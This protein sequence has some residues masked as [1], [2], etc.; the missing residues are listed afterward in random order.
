MKTK[1]WLIA[2]LGLI[3]CGGILFGG[4][5]MALN[6]DFT[7]LSTVTYETNIHSPGSDFTA[8]VVETDTANITFVPTDEGCSVTCVDDIRAKHQVY[9]EDGTLFIINDSNRKWYDHIGI[10]IGS[11]KITVRLPQ[12]QYEAL[13]VKT[14]TGDVILDRELRFGAM[15]LTVTTGSLQLTGISAE[16]LL[17]RSTTGRVYLSQVTCTGL[18]GITVDT[19]RIVAKDVHCR[20]LAAT[21]G[22]GDITLINVLA[23]ERLTVIGGT[24]DVELSAC[25]AREINVSTATGNV[26]GTLRSGKTFDAETDTG[27]VRVPENSGHGTCHIRTKTGDIHITVE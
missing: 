19:G 8:I 27:R 9:V 22:T 24:S 7:K 3:L 18:L 2:A 6:W 26:R 15:D 1:T 20:E 21:G 13:T 14:A 4:V 12:K 25:D 5:M 16:S 17:L 10:H 23:G 11:P